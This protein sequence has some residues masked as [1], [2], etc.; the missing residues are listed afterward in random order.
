MHESSLGCANCA[1]DDLQV[2]EADGRLSKSPVCQRMKNHGQSLLLKDFS[3][4]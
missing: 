3:G 1:D 4:I 2:H